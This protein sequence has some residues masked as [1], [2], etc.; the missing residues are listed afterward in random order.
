ML[1]KKDEYD[2]GLYDYTLLPDGMEF[3][4]RKFAIAHRNRFTINESDY[5]VAYVRTT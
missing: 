4:P 5:V 2:E 1:G 3:V